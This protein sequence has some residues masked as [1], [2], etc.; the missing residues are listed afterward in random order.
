MSA[1]EQPWRLDPLPVL[2]DAARW[3]ELAAGLAQRAELLDRLL[4]D[5]YGP[6]RTL[7]SGLLPPELVLGH[8]GYLR[9]WAR[10]RHT[11]T[12]ASC[13]WPAPTSPAPSRAG[14]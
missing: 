11:P 1:A 4:A 13:S 7:R 9:G 8:A 12:G 2:L 10:D 3:A 5:L 6:R 14:S